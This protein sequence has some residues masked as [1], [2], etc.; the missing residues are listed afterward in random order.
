MHMCMKSIIESRASHSWQYRSNCAGAMAAP[1]AM[2]LQ[3]LIKMSTVQLASEKLRNASKKY[4]A[5]SKLFEKHESMTDLQ[6]EYD[7]IRKYGLTGTKLGCK[8]WVKIG[9][10]IDEE[11]SSGGATVEEWQ[12]FYVAKKVYIFCLNWGRPT[13]IKF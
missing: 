9:K 7:F 5:A 6:S 3:T 2:Q 8:H 13:Q 12:A 11:E 10:Q 4:V 1:L